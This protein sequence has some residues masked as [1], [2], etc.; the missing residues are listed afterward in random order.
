MHWTHSVAGWS[1]SDGGGEKG[2][3]QGVGVTA[4]GVEIGPAA[5]AVLT[6]ADRRAG[7]QFDVVR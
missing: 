7:C 2:D 4:A 6:C 3:D 1:A 5:Y